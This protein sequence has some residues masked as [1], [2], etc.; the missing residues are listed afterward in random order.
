MKQNIRFVTNIE[1]RVSYN[2]KDAFQF[3]KDRPLHWLQ[4]LC[5][6]ILMKLQAYCVDYKTVY[7][8]RSIDTDSFMEQLLTQRE[9]LVRLFNMKPSTLLI[10]SEDYVEL[11]REVA[12]SNPQYFSFDTSYNHD[13][14]I[15][16]LKVHVIPW[17]K[18]CLVMPDKLD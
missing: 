12:F 11:M 2:N 3:R 13:L 9:N 4:K 18:G 1:H 8:T 5:L 7:E 6:F 16:G 17:M 10:G 15:L 14:E